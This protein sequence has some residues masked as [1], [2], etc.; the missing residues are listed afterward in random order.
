MANNYYISTSPSLSGGPKSFF[1]SEIHL[2]SWNSA[3][4]IFCPKIHENLVFQNLIISISKLRSLVALLFFQSNVLLSRL[5]WKNISSRSL[6][7]FEIEIFRFW[8]TRFTRFFM[9]FRRTKNWSRWISWN[10][11]YLRNEKRF[12]AAAKS[13]SGTYVVV[14][15]HP[16]EC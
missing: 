13:R 3:S 4:S 16:A 12:R 5:D 8:K 9:D 14:V 7:S 15:C 2:V 10:K 11:L 1:I 6:L